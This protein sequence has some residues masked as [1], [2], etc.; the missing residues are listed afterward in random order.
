MLA[1]WNPTQ[2]L[3]G[4]W[5]EQPSQINP[6]HF[7][8][9]ARLGIAEWIAFKLYAAGGAVISTFKAQPI[10]EVAP[11]SSLARLLEARHYLSE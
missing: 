7:M 4:G 11:G 3:P 2:R 10:P 9:A 6:I 5:R 1:D 8:F